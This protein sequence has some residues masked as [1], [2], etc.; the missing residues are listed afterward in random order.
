MSQG[1]AKPYTKNAPATVTPAPAKSPIMEALEIARRCVRD[2]SME[3]MQGKTDKTT[4]RL[5]C[6]RTAMQLARLEMD[7]SGTGITGGTGRAT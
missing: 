7:L 3:L 2:A 5:E 1:Y 6:A 4:H